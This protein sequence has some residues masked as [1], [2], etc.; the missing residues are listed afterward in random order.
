MVDPAD[1]VRPAP[2]PL[3]T[4]IVPPRTLGGISVGDGRRQVEARLGPGRRLGIPPH[5][6]RMRYA[7]WGIDE[8]D[9]YVPAPG[10]EPRV[11]VVTTRDPRYH[12]RQGVR[13]GSPLSLVSSAAGMH[14]YNSGADCQQGLAYRR[15]GV[16]YHLRDGRVRTIALVA[17]AD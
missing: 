5:V 8:I 1:A 3:T 4:L 10:R 15:P 7:R 14:C 12:T 16:V 11:I 6:L 2:G 9:Y 13:V 17:F